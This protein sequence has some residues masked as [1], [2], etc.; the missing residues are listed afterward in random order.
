MLTYRK[1]R[2]RN[3]LVAKSVP[4]GTDPRPLELDWPLLLH[5]PVRF[6]SSKQKEGSRQRNLPFIQSV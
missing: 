4:V 6:L 3:L 1:E 2:E 5:K